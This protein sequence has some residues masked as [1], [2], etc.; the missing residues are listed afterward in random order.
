MSS[1]QNTDVL[2]LSPAPVVP[3]DYGNR[4]RI[5]RV[6]QRLKARGARLH[7]VLYPAEADW[8]LRL[9]VS[10]F[11]AH[12]TLFETFHLVPPTRPLHPGAEGAHHRLDEWWDPAIGSYLDWLARIQR[13]DAAIV[14]YTWL[15]KA[16]D[17]LPDAC[18]KI[19]DTHDRFSGRKELFI[20]NGLEPEFFYLEPEEEARA[21][22]RADVVWAIKR[23]EAD[24]FRTMTDTPVLTL[25]HID[26]VTP[27]HTAR[28]EY[29]RIGLIGANNNLNREN[30]ERFLD[31][32]VAHVRRHLTQVEVV[33]AGS[34]CRILRPRAESFIRFLGYVDRTEDFYRAVDAV[35]VPMQF[36]TGLKIKTAEALSFG[37]PVLALAHAFEGFQ[38]AHPWHT[39]ADNGEILAAVAALAR[40]PDL[41]RDLEQASLRAAAATDAEV[42]AALD[43]SLAPYRKIRQPV[44][45]LALNAREARAR[46]L[47]VDHVL[48]SA[49][50]L[51]HLFPATGVVFLGPGCPDAELCARLSAIGSVA[52]VRDPGEPLPEDPPPRW[53]SRPWP[54]CARR[55]WVSGP[56]QRRRWRPSPT[57][58]PAA[59]SC[60]SR[61]WRCRRRGIP[62][63][64]TPRSSRRW[65]ALP[66][67]RRS[68]PRRS[69]RGFCPCCRSAAGT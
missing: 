69:I 17:H 61:R 1:W 2:I 50:F 6:C 51:R 5:H 12:Q 31:D 28:G 11:K 39:L 35:V 68:A 27:L 54:S 52:L 43:A 26:P 65:R 25:P 24:V 46:P 47:L 33:V 10:A 40:Q 30:F 22:A 23:E 3:L 19:L 41:L 32:C 37:K 57:C 34:V 13:F 45:W 7:F 62:L 63:P 44:F 9:P 59:S 15:S 8:R 67:G 58:P 55:R 66:K 21:F 48:E 56:Q 53:S 64:P 18:L 16:L 36:S 38:P 20:A 4:L 60:R 42:E 14:N 49:D 29:L